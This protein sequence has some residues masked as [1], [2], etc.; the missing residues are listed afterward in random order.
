MAVRAMSGRGI[1]SAA[2][3]T[4]PDVSDLLALMNKDLALTPAERRRL[5]R[6]AK[7]KRGHAAPPGTG[8]AGETCGSCA[9]L[10]RKR[11][12]KTYLKCELTRIVWT[13]GAGTDV[14]ARD[15]ACSRWEKTE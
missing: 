8:P 7:P 3:Q 5:E 2:M 15:P 6:G 9:N 4:R 14:R 10:I 11:M 1:C 13:G 12:S